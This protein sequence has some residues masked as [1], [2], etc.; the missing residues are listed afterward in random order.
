MSRRAPPESPE[1]TRDHFSNPPQHN[2]AN[3]HHGQERWDSSI[4]K[5]GL[6]KTGRVINKL[7][8]D[9]E[10]LKRDIQIERLR[11]EEARQAAKLLEEKMERMA[12]EH[13]ARLLEA[14]VTKTLLARKERQVE[15][16]SAQVGL[17]KKKALEALDRERNWRE[18][19][20]KSQTDAKRRIEG[21]EA[22]S[23]MLEG[24]YNAISS[25]WKDQ[26]NE[27]KRA[28]SKLRKEIAAL[29]QERKKDDE[30]ISILCDL[31]DQQDCNIRELA[32]QKNSLSQQFQ[33]YKTEQEHALK[34]IKTHAR[35][36]EEEQVRILEETRETLHRLK[37]VSNMHK[38]NLGA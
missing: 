1:S 6:G 24:R 27:V 32:Q 38:I 4:G 23:L 16:L 30:K 5:A 3:E 14:Q 35:E 12:A 20:E 33:T 22:K 37:W 21:A 25:H 7:V 13:E 2:H 11:A 19:M 17:E 36:T 9:N 8:S 29:V 28:T 34:D 26:G 18:E 31:C 10:A 15:S